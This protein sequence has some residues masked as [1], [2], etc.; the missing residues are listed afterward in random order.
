[1]GIA[2]MWDNDE[3]TIIRMEFNRGWDF[4]G[5][6][7]AIEQVHEWSNEANNPAFRGVIVDLTR[8]TFPPVGALPHFKYAVAGGGDN[9]RPV[10]FVGS[11]PLTKRLFEML[12]SA[13]K[14]QR[15][16]HFVNT[17]EQAY[18]ILQPLTAAIRDT[19]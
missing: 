11:D 18:A 7:K 2:V 1:M 3:Q 8:E 10:V 12:K 16:L 17:L 14:V 5:F 6:R 4:G 13:Y 9:P 15:P 19:A